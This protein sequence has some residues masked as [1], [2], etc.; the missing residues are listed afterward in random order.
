M[1]SDRAPVD[2]L[3]S[4]IL[5]VSSLHR[6]E[7]EEQIQNVRNVEMTTYKEELIKK[8]KAWKA[9]VPKEE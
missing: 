5:E 3:N 4:H 9:A 8:G 1:T 7:L 6:A 2:I